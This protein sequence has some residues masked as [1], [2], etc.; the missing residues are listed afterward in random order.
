MPLGSLHTSAHV[1]VIYTL[2]C[3]VLKNKVH[4]IQRH[5]WLLKDIRAMETHGDMIYGVCE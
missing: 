3:S 1:L 5:T 4:T 2:F